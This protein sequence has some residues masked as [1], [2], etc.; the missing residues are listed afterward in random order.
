MGP[1]FLDYSEARLQ[2]ERFLP[3]ALFGYINRGTEGENA[4][5]SLRAAFDARR[6]VPRVLRVTSQPNLSSR[7]LG[8]SH[9]SPFVVAPTALAGLVR[10]GG[11]VSLA[12]AASVHKMPVCLSTQAST[13]IEDVASAVPDAELWF[14]LYVWKD[15]AETWRLL[16]RVRQCGVETL[17]LTVDTPANPKKVHNLRNGFSIPLK[18]SV[19]LA[20]DLVLHWQWALG[21]LRHGAL[22]SFANYPQESSVSVTQAVHDP[23]F[24]L[25]TALDM[26]FV[27]ELRRRWHGKLLLKGILHPED[28]KM[29]VEA[30][31]DGIVASSH[32]GR[33]LDLSIPPISVLPRLREAVPDTVILA[34]SG[35][36]RGSD[37]ASLLALGADGVLLGRA[38]L[39]GLAAGGE[40]GAASI[41]AILTEEL[42]SFM[43]FAGAREVADLARLE[44]QK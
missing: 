25:D 14:Q 23:R 8:Q 34:D 35:V 43:V 32:G 42:R 9:P 41:L 4:L 11:E 18:P 39:Y 29:A 7:F 30:G 24:A 28:A 22:P 40:A 17:L 2:A 16:D 1:G 31:C 13:R 38:P 26:A 12:R 37:A 6:V 21:L 19:R 3:R 15:R 44:W 20:W 5:Q 27:G 10:H 33:N 36:Q